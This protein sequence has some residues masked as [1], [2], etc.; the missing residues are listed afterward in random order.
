MFYGK[1]LR[2]VVFVLEEVWKEDFDF[3]WVF[4]EKLFE[5]QLDIEQEWVILVVFGDLVKSIIKI[6]F[7][8]FKDNFDK[9]IFVF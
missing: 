4:Y 1:G 9:E 7:E 8:M 6:K 3:F 2:L 5:K